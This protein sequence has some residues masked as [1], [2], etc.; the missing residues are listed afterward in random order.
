VEL[1]INR[2][3]GEIH[4]ASLPD[5]LVGRSPVGNDLAILFRYQHFGVKSWGELI[6]KVAALPNARVRAHNTVLPY[7]FPEC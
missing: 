6:K 2:G 7:S 4:L 1:L 5:L 3:R